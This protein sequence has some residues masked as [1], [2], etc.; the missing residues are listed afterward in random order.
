MF[1]GSSMP[2]FLRVTN[3]VGLHAG[4]SA[5]RARQPRLHPDAGVHGGE[6]LQQHAAGHAGDDLQQLSHRAEMPAA[7]RWRS[8]CRKRNG[9]SP[10]MGADLRLIDVRDPDEFAYC[11]LPGAELIPLSTLP[12]E[13]AAQAA[14]QVRR[15]HPV[16]PPRDAFAAG[17]RA[18]APAR[19]HERAQH[20]GRHRPLVDGDR[21]DGAALLS[22][23]AY[24]GRVVPGTR[25]STFRRS[26]LSA[27]KPVASAWL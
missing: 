8:A 11:R 17:G 23:G 10:R 27:M 5:R 25:A 19:L 6:F 7:R 9:C 13:A 26:A 3:G 12:S 16:L 1:L 4:L 21:P 24:F 15:H 22:G 18:F 14:G 2:F 20:G